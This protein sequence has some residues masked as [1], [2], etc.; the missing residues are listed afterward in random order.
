MVE[1]AIY[2]VLAGLV[3]FALRGLLRWRFD[4]RGVEH[5][6]THG[7]AVLAF[8]HHSYLDFFAVGL[9]VYYQRR[10]RPRFL[11][12]AELFRTP[13]FGWVLRRSGQVPVDRAS[14]AGRA[15]AFRRAVEQLRGGDL[16]AIAPEQTISQSFELLPF[17]TG[18]VRMA[19]AAG[20]PIIPSVAWG[21]QR[22]ATKGRPIRPVWRIPV[23]VRYGEPVHVPP[24]ADPA[25]VTRALQDT[26]AAML[27]EVIRSY[28]DRPRP[29]DDWWVP[30]RY[31][32]SAPP[33]EEVLRAHLERLRGWEEGEQR[34]S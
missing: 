9:P 5:V 24:D 7:G 31:G 1:R 32:G 13:V 4:V 26:M 17:R 34:A 15:A 14:A 22:L 23:L 11:A 12:K 8:N 3:R 10:R 29:G 19:Q 2:A 28:P 30:A 6:P 25:E 27:D 21:D 33:H 18:A 20:V 16:I